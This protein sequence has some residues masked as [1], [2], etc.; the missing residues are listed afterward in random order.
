MS[1]TQPERI[2]DVVIIG[3]GPAGSSRHL[4]RAGKSFHL[5]FG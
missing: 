1:D 2:Y 4:H 5:G 3:G